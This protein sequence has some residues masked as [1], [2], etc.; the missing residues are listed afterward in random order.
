MVSGSFHV[1]LVSLVAMCATFARMKALA[2]LVF[3]PL[4]LLFAPVAIVGVALASYKQL[5]ISK[6]LGVS[7]TGIDVMSGRWTMHVFGMREDEATVRMARVLPNYSPAGMWMALFPLWVYSRIAGGNSVYPRQVAPGQEDIRDLVTA[8]TRYFDAIIERRMPEVEQFVVMG[9]GYDTRC[10][11]SLRAGPQRCFEADEEATQ[12][13]KIAAVADAGLG[14]AG[15]AFVTVDFE[16]EDTFE[17]LD[18]AGY[19]ASKK[20]LFLWEGVTLYLTEESVRRALRDM[21]QHA[22]PGS[23]IV[24]DVYGERFTAVGKSGAA[25]KALELTDEALGFSLPFEQDH[26]A[27]LRAFVESEGLQVGETNFMGIHDKRGPFMVVAEFI[28]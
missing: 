10:Y 23:I 6:R 7:Q 21:K 20:T 27:R 8:R 4:Q 25:K 12:Q 22:A 17:R 15:V 18:A 16:K 28:T 19:D 14:T 1:R 26:D 3:I 11:G 24:A 2:L 9:A 13:V 5:L